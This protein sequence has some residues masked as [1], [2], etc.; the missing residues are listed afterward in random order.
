[1]RPCIR[2]Q[3]TAAYNIATLPTPIATLFQSRLYVFYDDLILTLTIVMILLPR[4][5]GGRSSTSASTEARGGRRGHRLRRSHSKSRDRGCSRGTYSNRSSRSIAYCATLDSGLQSGGLPN[6]RLNHSFNW[7][8]AV[9]ATNYKTVNTKRRTD[10]RDSDLASVRNRTT[11][12]SQKP[13]YYAQ[14]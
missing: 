1:M 3:L 10:T 8:T 4:V 9:A 14:V 2:A 13:W 7:A 5:A 11:P 12:Y 6:D